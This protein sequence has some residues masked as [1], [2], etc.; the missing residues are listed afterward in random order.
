MKRPR[1]FYSTVNAA[2]AL[3]VSRRTVDRVAERERI[4][5][6]V[7]DSGVRH[8]FWT[9]PQLTELRKHLRFLNG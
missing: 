2:K 6:I 5:P 9:R 7:I 3:G 1:F 8:H 4:Q